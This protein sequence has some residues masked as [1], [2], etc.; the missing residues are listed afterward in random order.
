MSAPPGAEGGAVV[1]TRRRADGAR[2]VRG[3]RYNRAVSRHHG[4]LLPTSLPCPRAT[5]SRDV[6]GDAEAVGRT[7]A[8][9]R[10]AA[11]RRVGRH[12]EHVREEWALPRLASERDVWVVEDAAGRWS[13]TG[14]AGW[15]RRPA[16]SSPSSSSTPAHGAAGSS[17][18]LLG[19]CEARAAEPLARGRG[20]RRHL[21][22]WAHE[23]DVRRIALYERR[24]YRHERTFLRLDR[25]LDDTSSAPVWP[26]GITVAAFRPGIDDA[27]VHA[28]REEAFADHSGPAETDLEEWL[29]SRFAH[30]GRTSASGWSPG[31]A[32]RWW[33]ASRP[34]RRR[35]RYMGELF[36][37][38]P[39]RGRGIGQAPLMLE[40]CAELRRRG[41]RSAF[42]GVDAANTR[43][44]RLHESL[45]F[46]S[47]RGATLL[48]EKR[49]GG[50]DAPAASLSPPRRRGQQAE[51]VMQ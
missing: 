21:G 41:M 8:R 4:S 2:R 34:W 5:A 30:E 42:F 18:L 25:D 43:A 22:V 20:R 51:R 50:T 3:G 7:Q 46:R 44:L 9:R 19:L 23:S 35:G 37:R 48:F 16:R 6:A 15:R 47:T 24:G 45:G 29:A 10:V 28:A 11:A 26:A 33:A 36:V 1:C 49:L 17:E 40:E 27:A 31:T 12:P 38:R 32:T 13:A 39:W 14:S